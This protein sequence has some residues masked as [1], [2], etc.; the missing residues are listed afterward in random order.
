MPQ[1][2]DLVVHA[3]WPTAEPHAVQIEHVA[4]LYPLASLLLGHNCPC[5]GGHIFAARVSPGPSQIVASACPAF[6]SLCT[7]QARMTDKRYGAGLAHSIG[8]CEGEQTN[9]PL[10]R[11]PRGATLSANTEDRRPPHGGDKQASP[12]SYLIRCC[13][14]TKARFFEISAQYVSDREDFVPE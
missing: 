5:P 8:G 9:G 13:T 10:T 14:Q 7:T 3:D 2:P 1:W 11:R 12:S 4:N 6:S